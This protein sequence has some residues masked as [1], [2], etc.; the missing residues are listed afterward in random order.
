M[1]VEATREAYKVFKS[2]AFAKDTVGVQ[3]A[4]K[5]ESEEDILDFW[6]KTSSSTW[7]MMGTAR[8]GRNESTAVVD[9]DFKVFGV[10]N[11]RVADMSIIPIIVK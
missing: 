7:H 9:K 3:L 11:L 5:S 8:M 6:K 1:A 2:E 4:P 10:E